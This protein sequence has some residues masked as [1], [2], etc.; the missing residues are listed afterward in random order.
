M[1]N[2]EYD[3]EQRRLKLELDRS[4]KDGDYA[5][6]RNA[7]DRKKALK[8]AAKLAKQRDRKAA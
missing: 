2:R 8:R 7:V 3:K 6:A 4:F 1:D 5:G